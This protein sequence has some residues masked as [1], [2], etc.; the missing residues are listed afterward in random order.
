MLFNYLKLTLR[1][2]I[3]NPFFTFVNV[4]GLSIGFAVFFGL[5]EFASKELRTDQHYR[6]YERI[7]R[8]CTD[9]SW[10]DDGKNWG[11]MTWGYASALIAPN[12]SADFPEVESFSRI[13]H[14]IVFSPLANGHMRE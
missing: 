8:I 5:W 3:R 9:W 13:L 12:I 11:R 14:V 2:L 7:I 1:L 4:F 6:D 10:T